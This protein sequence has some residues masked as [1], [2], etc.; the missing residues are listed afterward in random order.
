[1]GKLVWA[2][3]ITTAVYIRKMGLHNPLVSIVLLGRKAT[4]SSSR[5][6]PLVKGLVSISVLKLAFWLIGRFDS[7][8]LTTIVSFSFLARQEIKNS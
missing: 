7:K 2:G 3:H 4:P 6:N 5:P 8:F 1:M